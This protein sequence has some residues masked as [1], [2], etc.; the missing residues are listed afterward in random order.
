MSKPHLE[1][2]FFRTGARRPTI[3]TQALLEF[4]L[5]SYWDIHRSTTFPIQ[6]YPWVPGVLGLDS[7]YEVPNS[8]LPPVPFPG[9]CWVASESR[10]PLWLWP[11]QNSPSHLLFQS[12]HSVMTRWWPHTLFPQNSLESHHFTCRETS[13]PP[14]NWQ[15]TLDYLHSSC[16]LLPPSDLCSALSGLYFPPK[17]Q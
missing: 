8:V 1:P 5:C 9:S 11:G 16:S 3:C 12:Y 6:K 4:L 15:H 2:S 7:V 14:I 13:F 17:R 10:P